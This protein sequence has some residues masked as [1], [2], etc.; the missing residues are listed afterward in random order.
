[1]YL[2]RLKYSQAIFIFSLSWTSKTWTVL[3]R[4]N[5]WAGWIS[6]DQLWWLCYVWMMWGFLMRVDAFWGKFIDWVLRIGLSV[7]CCWCWV[8][9]DFALF[10]WLLIRFCRI[11]SWSSSCR[12][13]IEGV[14]F[15]SLWFTWWGFSWMLW[16]V[17]RWLRFLWIEG[18]VVGCYFVILNVEDALTG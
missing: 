14:I 10:D 17:R 3:L 15:M 16:W 2:D 13:V 18:L 5:G 12:K 7:W 4:C 6:M 11:G 8:V 1:M 9:C